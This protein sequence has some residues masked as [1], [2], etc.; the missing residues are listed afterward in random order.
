ME[1]GDKGTGKGCDLFLFEDAALRLRELRGHL[2]K[3]PRV[4]SGTV[5]GGYSNVRLWSP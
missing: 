5:R 1:L 4:P 3:S 2:G